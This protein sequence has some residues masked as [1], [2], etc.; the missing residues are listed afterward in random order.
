[1]AIYHLN[2][3]VIS[4][5]KGKSA[6]AA[7]AYRAAEKIKDERTGLTFDY[8][9]K[10]GVYATEII[11]PDNAP[12]WVKSRA[13]LWNEVELFE[14][15]KNSRLAREFDIALPGELTHSQ[16]QELV[17]NFVREQLVS[18]GMIADV[19]FHDLESHNP[20]VHI[21]L[22]TRKIS[23]QGFSEKER[24]WDSRDFLVGIRESWSNYANQAL[25][26]AGVIERIDHRTLEEQ[27]INRIPQIHL[28]ADVAAMMDKGIFTERGEEY[29]RICAANQKIEALE[30]QLAATEEAIALLP[31]QPSNQTIQ[32]T[33]SSQLNPTLGLTEES[34]TEILSDE[35]VEREREATPTDIV[36]RLKGITDRLGASSQRAEELGEK[37]RGIGRESE[38]LIGDNTD[39]N[40]EAED[41]RNSNTDT[42]RTAE[43]RARE[44]QRLEERIRSSDWKN[45]KARKSVGE[46]LRELTAQ[47]GEKIQQFT[48]NLRGDSEDV[49]QRQVQGFELDRGIDSRQT[50]R[51]AQ[52]DLGYPTV[53]EPS[54]LGIQSNKS[55]QQR[56][57]AP[58]QRQGQQ[59]RNPSESNREK[60]KQVEPAS[61]PSPQQKPLSESEVNQIFLTATEAL[62]RYGIERDDKTT[63]NN[64]YY[65]IQKFSVFE[66]YG[67]RS[68]LTIDALDGRGRLLTLKGQNFHPK[69]LKI[70]EN[71]LN[72]EDGQTFGK[73]QAALDYYQQIRQFKQDTEKI[74]RFLGVS[75]PQN[76][77]LGYGTLDGKKY[78]IISD[79]LAFRVIA[80]DG[81]GEIFNYPNDSNVRH[82]EK[83]AEVN[84][85]DEDLE[86]FS[87]AVSKLEQ[88]LQQSQNEQLEHQRKRQQGKG[89]SR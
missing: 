41:F 20:H 27:G 63:F 69:N 26:Q 21:M 51:I 38:S 64:S 86:F 15:R 3:K 10:Q 59:Q 83:Q 54:N 71:R 34:A 79:S 67:Y 24:S 4:R 36:E 87:E 39:N 40:R 72:F 30:R 65:Q 73:I 62:R 82:P 57:V 50:D 52:G 88:Y 5:G 49:E 32:T 46:S 29:L 12:D 75:D 8:S 81:R 84:L 89:F 60:I 61:Q 2:A 43:D 13:R 28:G 7:A 42:N 85:T 11:A 66:T 44:F 68:Y 22:T 77:S 16:K 23:K 47:L 6:T 33:T 55:S 14:N 45:R 17:R 9:R 74:L 80:K 35:R 1:M 18:Q 25:E 78:Q 19:A 48:R 70:E 37:L 31:P 58:H 76:P 53:H 56:S